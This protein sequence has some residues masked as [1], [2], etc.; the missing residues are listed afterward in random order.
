MAKSRSF[1][2]QNTANRFVWWLSLSGLVIV[3][4]QLTKF[5]SLN[6]IAQSGARRITSFL[7]WVLVFNPGAAFSFL[8]D[9]FGWQKWLLIGVGVIAVT[10]MLW[11][12]K[13][14][15]HE[16]IFCFSVALILGG[17]IGNLI[18][19]FHHGAVVDFID[20][21]Y[22]DYHW[23]AFNIADSAITVGAILL[24]VDELNRVIRRR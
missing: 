7:N 4:D 18:D 1:F 22:L 16:G 15:S 3:L 14:H 24:I 9:G 11:L 17:A 2:S 21:Y 5:I 20:V 19:R 10:V 6:V 8:G 12:L 13:R 23:P